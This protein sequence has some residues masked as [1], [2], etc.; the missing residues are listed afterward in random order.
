MFLLRLWPTLLAVVLGCG[1]APAAISWKDTSANEDGFRVYRITDH[2]TRVIAE[3]GAGVTEF[4]DRNAPA[5]SCY[6]VT[7]FNGS[8]E[9][10]AT[11]VVC[12]PA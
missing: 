10:L 7:A 11:P 8:G 2:G 12:G 3:V 9:S 5:R 6:R 4:V 1:A